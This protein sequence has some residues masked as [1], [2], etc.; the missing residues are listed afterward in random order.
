MKDLAELRHSA[1]HVMAQAVK[2]LYPEVKLAIG[3]AIADGFY[4]DFEK[5]EPFTPEDLEKISLKMKEIVKQ[6]LKFEHYEKP[7]DEAIKYFQDKNEKYKVELIND[8]PDANMS[9]YKQGDFVD[10]CKG[11]HVYYTGGLK[12][13]KLLS[14]LPPIGAVMRREIAYNVFM[15]QFSLPRKN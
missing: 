6:N 10:L 11:P 12:H 9:F 1:S 2:E 5:K 13:F 8:L 3:P 15:A 14:E 7:R 4:Y